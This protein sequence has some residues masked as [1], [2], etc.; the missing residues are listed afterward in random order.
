MPGALRLAAAAAL[1]F[2][3]PARAQLVSTGATQTVSG[4]KVPDY[5]QNNNLKSVLYGDFARVRPDGIA[6][7]T[8]VKLEF[9]KEGAV[10]MTVT[11]PRCVYNQKDGTARSD[12][13]VEIVREGL[14]ITGKGFWWGAKQ[15]RFEIYS[16]ARVEIRGARKGMESGGL[17]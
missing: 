2:A 16:K 8:N 6:E 3:A 15:E 4:F 11:S 17:P 13:D 7:I 9:Y 14:K 10:E 5:D 1:L 12:A